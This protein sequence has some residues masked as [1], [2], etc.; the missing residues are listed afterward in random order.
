MNILIAS[1]RSANVNIK[2]FDIE[3]GINIRSYQR[4]GLDDFLQ[5][6]VYEMI[7]RVDMLLDKTFVLEESWEEIPLVLGSVYRCLDVLLVVKWLENSI[8][9]ITTWMTMSLL[10]LL[11]VLGLGGGRS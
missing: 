2:V 10:L 1:L 8:E 9:T 7:E 5:L 4:F 11:P 6:D 3:V